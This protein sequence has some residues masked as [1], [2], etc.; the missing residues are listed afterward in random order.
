MRKCGCEYHLKMQQL[1]AALRKWRLKVRKLI[2]AHDPEH[3]C[4]A[5]S[6]ENYFQCTKDLTSFGNH[7]CP[8]ERH[9]NGLR[10]LECAAGKCD[11][12]KSAKSNLLVCEA[13]ARFHNLPV[14][15][16][17]IRAIMIANRQSSEWA[18]M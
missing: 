12:C 7:V 6:N 11:V 3:T 15:Y 17:W 2:L 8:C 18:Y 16:K 13:E 10:Q 1:I 9:Q 4:Q 14:K 5:C